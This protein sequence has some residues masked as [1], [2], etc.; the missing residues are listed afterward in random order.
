MNEYYYFN[1]K[2]EEDEEERK[3]KNERRYRNM[4]FLYSKFCARQYKI[5]N[6]ICYN[7][8]PRSFPLYIISKSK[9]QTT[10]TNQFSTINS[11]LQTSNS[12]SKI[13]YAAVII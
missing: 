3:R 4:L 12:A 5:N 7:N 13:F 11:N 8:Q 6:N 9:Q 1:I 10:I 2:K